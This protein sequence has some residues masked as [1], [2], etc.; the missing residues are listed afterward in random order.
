[1]DQQATKQQIVERIKQAENILVTVSANP[2]VD[3]LAACIGLTLLINKM[4]KTAT[5]VYSGKT[6]SVMEFLKPEKTL[7][8]NTDSLR[9]FIIS[10]D[11]S[12]ADKLRYKVEDQVVRIFIT[13]YKTKLTE[14]DLVFSEG[15][16]NV[17]VV[18]AL[19][20]LDRTHLDLAITA[21]GRILHDA[22]V[23]A[24]SAGTGKAPD[25]GQVNWQDPTASSLSE[26]LVS[27][28][29]ALGTGLIDNQIATSFLTGIVAETERF[30]NK[31]TTPK[32]M[33]MSAQLMA[34]GA[35]QQL[36]I[37][38][39]QP[40][41]PPPPPLKSAAPMPQPQK[42]N[43]A[44]PPPKPVEPKKEEGILSIAHEASEHDSNEVE[45]DTKEIRIDKQGNLQTVEEAAKKQAEI[46]TQPP[47]QVEK[48]TEKKLSAPPPSPPPPPPPPSP[49][50]PPPPPQTNPADQLPSL[51]PQPP[52]PTIKL[53]G[54]TSATD[55]GPPPTANIRPIVSSEEDLNNHHTLLDPLGRGPNLGASFS[56]D[57][58]LGNNGGNSEVPVDPINNEGPV[59][60][61]DFSSKAKIVPPP[62]PT[63]KNPFAPSAGQVPQAGL[64][65]S[66]QGGLNPDSARQAVE[67]AYATTPYN[68]DFNPMAALGSMPGP[69]L[70]PAADSNLMPAPA[71]QNETPSLSLPMNNLTP[72][73]SA[74]QNTNPAPPAPPPMPPPIMP[75]PSL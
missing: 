15:D 47:V 5:A 50:P 37:S 66:Q 6:P 9:D 52:I 30:S 24:L 74:P 18:V 20:V 32:V 41:P 33:T 42:P 10:L 11:K 34:A 17:D 55:L 75:P 71:P 27:I 68:P 12:K 36:V 43:V 65:V 31:K 3:Q 26:M 23:I 14:K 56:A 28:S 72:P 4:G 46:Q 49:P 44:A 63:I 51:P 70:H 19:G 38:K 13:P 59:T 22:T 7:E 60:D 16:F 2:S 40:P 35:N 62:N 73:A 48:Q 39:L 1:M 54:H 45:I 61:N 67:S 64:P 58:T 29:E 53:D 8:P 21:H 25:L 69:E 57:T